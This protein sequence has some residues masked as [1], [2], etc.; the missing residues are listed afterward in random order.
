M[1]GSASE[2]KRGCA[3]RIL[4]RLI[5]AVALGLVGLELVLRF[6]LF[7]E[8]SL[9][10]RLGRYTRDPHD[11]AD[12]TTEDLYWSLRYRFNAANQ[13]E[14]PARDPI[15]GWRGRHLVLPETYGHLHEARVGERRPVLLFG[16]SFVQCATHWTDCFEGLMRDSE[17]AEELALLNYGVGGFG[18]D[19]IV[20]LLENA[21]LHWDGVE[22]AEPIVVVAVMVDDDLDRCILSF[23]DWPKPRFE[24]EGGELRV[25]LPEH[26]DNDAWIEANP[27]RATS[28]LWR[29]LVHGSGLLPHGVERRLRGRP[30]AEREKQA[31]ARALVERAHLALEARGIE[32]FFLMF[33]GQVALEA[34]GDY[35][36]QVPTLIEAFDAVGARW[37][38][39]KRDLREDLEA[40]GAEAADYFGV[41][42][43]EAGHYNPRG[44]EV[45]FR[46]I[47]RGVDGADDGQARAR[48]AAW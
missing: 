8:S 35:G 19:Q 13:A 21:L 16:D 15:V 17:R 20:L 9:G 28:W 26:A 39:A 12:L 4:P 18:F 33:P 47:L 10:R 38:D 5:L 30:A 14:P 22:G 45:A 42:G 36:W 11:Y 25:A 2:S 41:E 40:T 29:W 1:D 7:S 46:A 44:N 31:L 27:P 48:G 23:R 32:H 37:V 43:V 24:L 34:E 3:R 6:S